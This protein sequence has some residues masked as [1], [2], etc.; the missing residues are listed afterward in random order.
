MSPRQCSRVLLRSVLLAALA[1][2]LIV[3]VTA[4]FNGRVQADTDFRASP[5]RAEP[6]APLLHPLTLKL[7]TFNIADGYLFTGN[8]AE[9]MRAIAEE[10]RACGWFGIM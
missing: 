6:P 1:P 10:L 7:V 9:R 5:L 3:C 8:R 4:L 2:P